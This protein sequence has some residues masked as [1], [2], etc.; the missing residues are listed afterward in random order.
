MDLLPPDEA[1]FFRRHLIRIENLVMDPD[2]RKGDDPAESPRH[3]VDVESY[4]EAGFP[5]R[6]RAWSESEVARAVGPGRLRGMGTGLFA[7]LE[8]LER[9]REAYDSRDETEAV[10]RAA[11]LAHYVGD[12][13]NP[14]HTTSNFDGQRT[15]QRGIHRRFEADLV[16]RRLDDVPPPRKGRLPDVRRPGA[17]AAA[18]LRLVHAWTDEVFAAD[19]RAAWDP[20]IYDAH[21]ERRFDEAAG[22][23]LTRSLQGGAE[24]L[25]AYLHAVARRA[26]WPEA[27]LHDLGRISP[28]AR[29]RPAKGRRGARRASTDE[30]AWVA[31]TAVCAA[32]A[33]LGV[34]AVR[35][36]SRR[37]R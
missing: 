23:V 19:R 9:F 2:D 11:D 10:L 30:T 18:R 20:V 35:K 37:S 34:L 6:G 25:A 5:L 26:P 22:P 1:A 14:L 12:L 16:A 32:S 31:L 27:D 7:L 3:F 4:E 21:Y 15:G 24:A 13:H 29:A 33:G 8:T 17:F 36:G 28:P